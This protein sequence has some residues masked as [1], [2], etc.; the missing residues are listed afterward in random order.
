[1]RVTI[2]NNNGD[3][4]GQVRIKTQ[5]IPN[6]SEGIMENVYALFNEMK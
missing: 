3:S 2:Q 4:V 1:M 5:N 6:G